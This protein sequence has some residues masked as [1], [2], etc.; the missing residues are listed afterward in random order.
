MG[1]GENAGY[2]NTLQ[3]NWLLSNKP[4]IE[5]MITDERE[6]SQSISQILGKKSAK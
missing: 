4:N 2:Q 6:L 5:T 1:K 3:G